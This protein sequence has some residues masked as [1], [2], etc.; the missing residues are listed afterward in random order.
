VPIAFRS[1]L[2]NSLSPLTVGGGAIA[3]SLSFYALSNGAVWYAWYP[4]TWNGLSKCYATALPFLANSLKSDL[5]F[6][7]GLFGAFALATWLATEPTTKSAAEA[8]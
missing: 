1:V 8:A 5:L 7:A 2:R 6:S 3:S 4:H